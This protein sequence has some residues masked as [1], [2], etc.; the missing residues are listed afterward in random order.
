MK[1]SLSEVQ[2]DLSL[3]NLGRASAQIVHDLKNQLN[4]LKLYAT[5]LRKRLEKS[6]R[7]IDELETVNKLLLGLDRTAA[8][9]SLLAQFGQPVNVKKQAGVD[10]EK[11][12]RTVAVGLN[13]SPRASGALTGPVVVDT[14]SIPLVGDFDAGVLSD[15]LKV[16]SLSAMK[17]LGAKQRD[18][19]LHVGLKLHAAPTPTAVIEWRGFHEFDHDPFRSFIGADEIRLSLAARTIEA[20]SGSAERINGVLRVS[21]PL[22]Q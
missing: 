16:I 3:Q 9:L 18:V 19:P 20:H 11:L 1:P 13:E 6:E 5:F 2:P 21:L 7:P 15:A 12:V 17:L 8:D 10:L 4:G 14:D 22:G